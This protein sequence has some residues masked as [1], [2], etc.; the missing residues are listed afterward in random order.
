M[1][2]IRLFTSFLSLQIPLQE[3][4]IIACTDPNSD[5]CLVPKYGKIVLA[6]QWLKGY[7]SHNKC[8]L[9]DIENKISLHGMWYDDCD[10]GFPS[11]CDKNREY[12]NIESI[13]EEKEEYGI[14]TFMR[15]NWVS[16]KGDNNKLWVH[17]FSKH[18]TCATTLNPSCFNDYKKY[19]DVVNYFNISMNTF[20]KEDVLS[21]LNNV[22]IVPTNNDVYSIEQI[23]KSSKYKRQYI[24]KFDRKKK[25]YYLIEIRICY[26]A[27]GKFNMD[28]VDCEDYG[29]CKNNFYFH[30]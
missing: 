26:L 1:S 3:N 8:N 21:D 20:L 25:V 28:V 16:F 9:N 12:E 29:N 10:K 18:G 2:I 13:L 24:C 22:N 5:P 4:D 23:K 19:D 6:T 17:E 7:C 30:K 27:R 14:L 15:S 11:N